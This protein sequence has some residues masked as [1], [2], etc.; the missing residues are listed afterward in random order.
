MLTTTQ[1]K[2][3]ISRAL[4]HAAWLAVLLALALLPAPALAQSQEEEHTGTTTGNYNVKQVFEMGYRWE[5]TTGNRNVYNT[6]VN[7]NPGPRLFEHSLEMRS[8]NHQGLLFDN[9]SLHSF[10][11]GG[12]PNNVTRLRAYKNRWYNFSATFRRDRNFWD[13]RLLANPL[14]PASYPATVPVSTPIFNIPFS[15]HRMEITR[16]LSD[17]NMTFAP[18]SPIRV[19]LGY[20][21]NISEGP[22]LTTFH[23]GT[24]VF[25]FQNW[26]NTLNSYQIGFDFKYLP[27]TNFSFDQFWHEYKGDT[28]WVDP[29]TEGLVIDDIT[30]PRPIFQL[31]NGQLVDIGTIYNFTVSQPCSSTA[32]SP[33]ITVPGSGTTPP[34]IKGACNGYLQY[35]REAKHRASYP[36]TQFSFQSSYLK[37]LDISGR[38]VFSNTDAQVVGTNA[39]AGYLGTVNFNGLMELYQGLVTRTLQRQFASSGPARIERTSWTGDVAFTWY[40][41]DHFRITNQFRYDSFRIPGLFEL[42]ELSGYPVNPAA[43]QP[44]ASLTDAVANFTPGLAPPAS[45]PTITSVGCPRHSSSS[46]AD[47]LSE[48]FNHLLRQRSIFD[49]VDLAYDFSRHFGGRI[50]Y[51]VRD[52]EIKISGTD[53]SDSVFF[54]TLPNRGGCTPG[55]TPPGRVAV[56]NPDGSCRLTVLPDPETEFEE[57]R[58]HSLLFGLWARPNSRFRASYDMELF[59]ADHA[60]TRISPR[61]RQRYK[62]RASYSPTDWASIVANFNILNQRNNVDQIFHRQSND[63]FAF[64]VSLMPDSWWGVDFGYDF[65]DIESRTNICFTLTT[66]PLP[67]GSGPCPITLPA[68][69]TFAISTYDNT[70]HF[71]FF[72]V[73]LKPVKR[74][75]TYFG[76][77]VSSTSGQTLILGPINA[78]TGPLAFNWHKPN[79]GVEI[80]LNK[81][82]MLKSSWSYYGYNE[83]EAPDVFTS[84]LDTLGNLIGRDF[85][86]NQFTTSVRFTF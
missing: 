85:R 10:G 20:S 81:F 66:T 50:G 14:N 25:L 68:Q 13:Y 16:R 63:T 45:C 48:Q 57:I 5:G 55:T 19:R 38:M 78:P 17:Y 67:P 60:F 37:N 65:N 31:S 27:K 30:L 71:G 79:A 28:T 58:E 23:E 83:K 42:L 15:P 34:T 3:A 76:Y 36:T 44:A 24:D 54:P 33:F 70:L 22:S 73:V 59:Y 82:V 32:T 2:A 4:F 47:I 26:K 74:V 61:Q 43:P 86:G 1:K 41:T 64:A 56:N 29:I 62:F 21:R 18:Q 6:F 69:T 49:Q 84:P 77:T 7:L 40:V 39:A 12:D 75:K 46:P 8:L 80:Q 52:R 9:F 53:S 11:Y 51:R 72:N 35:R